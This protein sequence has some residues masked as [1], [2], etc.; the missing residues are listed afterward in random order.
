MKFKFHTKFS[1]TS[2]ITSLTP[3][4][5]LNH[6]HFLSFPITKVGFFMLST[7]LSS[8]W[9]V[10]STIF[11]FLFPHFLSYPSLF[12]IFNEDK[13][14]LLCHFD[15]FKFFLYHD[16]INFVYVERV[17]D[18]CF[19][20]QLSNGNLILMCGWTQHLFPSLNVIYIAGCLLDSWWFKEILS[21]VPFSVFQ[22]RV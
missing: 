5:S 13:Q 1:C 15:S 4:L 20:R 6:I 10:N 19:T 8:Q 7:K 2:S 9:N 3:S 14:L 16:N 12:S 17:L 22:N 21:K 18:K 11:H